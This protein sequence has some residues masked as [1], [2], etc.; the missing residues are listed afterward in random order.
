M[1]FKGLFWENLFT[2]K[3]HKENNPSIWC[4]FVFLDWESL[5]LF[6]WS[7]FFWIVITNQKRKT[8]LNEIYLGIFHK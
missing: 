1:V 2:M 7:Y 6:L 4:L 5:F 8:D 3:K